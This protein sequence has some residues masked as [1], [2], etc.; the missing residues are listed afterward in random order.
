MGLDLSADYPLTLA[1]VAGMD[2]SSNLHDGLTPMP[3][4]GLTLIHASWKSKQAHQS[5]MLISVF[6]SLSFP[7]VQCLF[8]GREAQGV[9]EPGIQCG[10]PTRPSVPAEHRAAGSRSL[11]VLEELGWA[12]AR[13]CP[14]PPWEP[15]GEG[16]PGG[17]VRPLPPDWSPFAHCP[18]RGS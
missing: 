8:R 14:V 7:R 13:P 16:P 4:K 12:A 9:I 11:P 10:W 5:T 3:I 6:G 2:Y 15:C 17:H 18:L 1:H